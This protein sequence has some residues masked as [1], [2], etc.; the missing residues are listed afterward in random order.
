MAKYF[1]D[2]EFRR[3]TPPCS[4][5]EMSGEFMDVLDKVRA[6]A[7]IPLVLNSAYRTRSYELSHGRNGSSSH[8]QG[9]AVDIR[10]NTSQN[11]YKIVKAALECGVTRI[12]IGKTF[13]HLDIATDRVQQ[14]IFDYYD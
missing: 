10:C 12:G 2:S 13:V 7:G 4:I 8:C 3:C 6:R 9:K 14:V 11:R 1:N 5:S